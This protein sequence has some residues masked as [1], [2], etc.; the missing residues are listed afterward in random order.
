MS[1]LIRGVEEIWARVMES[2]CSK[3]EIH[4]NFHKTK[5]RA[6]GSIT[7]DKILLKATTLV[8]KTLSW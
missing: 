5:A 6:G 8:L 1:S 7:E 4:L 2:F 3:T